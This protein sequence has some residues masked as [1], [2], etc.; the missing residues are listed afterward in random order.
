MRASDA[1]PSSQILKRARIRLTS[2]TA[3]SDRRWFL[4]FFLSLYVVCLAY[5]V[6]CYISILLF[7]LLSWA[8]L[9][10]SVRKNVGFSHPPLRVIQ[11]RS[12]RS[13]LRPT[14][15]EMGRTEQKHEARFDGS[16]FSDDFIPCEALTHLTNTVRRVPI[17]RNKKPRT[18]LERGRRKSFRIT[19]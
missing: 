6:F 11:P 5:C 14:N 10:D 17:R 9:L 18:A 2:R 3:S 15:Y 7:D 1:S 4:W 19:E 13:V 12:S 8:S 16:S